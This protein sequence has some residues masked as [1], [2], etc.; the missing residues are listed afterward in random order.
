M[1]N[2]LTTLNAK[3]ILIT[4]LVLVSL[5][6]GLLYYIFDNPFV[7]D[8][9]YF[10]NR[11]AKKAYLLDI[12]PE[13]RGLVIQNVSGYSN[14]RVVLTVKNYRNHSVVIKDVILKE[15]GQILEVK[16]SIYKEIFQHTSDIVVSVWF[17]ENLLINHQYGIEVFTQRGSYIGDVDMDTAFLI[18]T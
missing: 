15:Q 7:I 11:R 12:K 16:K 9:L 10:A 6:G 5:F 1:V 4:V 3:Y 18:N 8:N 13:D 17:T 14:G 2:R